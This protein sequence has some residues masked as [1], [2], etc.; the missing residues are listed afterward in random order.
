MVAL[1]LFPHLALGL[2][3][4]ET[5]VAVMPL[6]AGD[7]DD[8]PAHPQGRIRNAKKLLTT[9]ALIMSVMLV[10]SSIVTTMLIPPEE[11]QEG[12]EAYG[13]A[14]AYLA[15]EH[16]GAVFGTI[17]DLSTVAI[18]WFAGASAM[19]GLLNLVPQY[20][21]RYGMAPEWARANRPLVLIFTA[22]TFV[23]TIL[24][25][26][27]VDAQGG[28][29]ATG[30]LVLMG[31]AALAVTI[32]GVAR[33]TGMGRLFRA[34]PHLRLHH[35][36][37]HRRTAGRPQDR[38]HLHR[39]HRH[40]LDGVAGAAVDRAAR[41][42][43]RSGRPGPQ[44]FSAMRRRGPVRIIA[45]RPDTGLPE[46]YEHKLKEAMESHHLTADDAVLFIEVRPG[47][48][49]EFSGVLQVSGATV[50]R[51]RVL[52]CVSPAIP[53]AIAALLLLRARSDRQDSARLLRLDRRQSD[54][55][56]DE[57]PRLR[58]R[59]HRAGHARSAAPVR[60]QPPP[61]AQNPCRLDRPPPPR[62]RAP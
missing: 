47:D 37:Q 61:A 6:V 5:G 48:V 19:V 35:D 42:G 57:V 7:P 3:G 51:H 52:R 16:L 29:Y 53:N 12:G 27:D 49:S 59:R 24:F 39:R 20:L 44:R 22:I 25:K 50:D 13:R 38:H 4:F 41:A 18:L 56:P 36:R 11:F 14:L 43:G 30:V 54:R 33:R 58:R 26:A 32:C 9:A 17:Y 46:E 15:H 34:D 31:S 8:T 62:R 23:V 45:N 55:L 21:P 2:S 10:G 60:A 28:A 1:L 40:Q